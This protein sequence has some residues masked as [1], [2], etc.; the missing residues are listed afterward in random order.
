MRPSP[1]NAGAVSSATCQSCS[2]QY[3]WLTLVINALLAVLKISVGFMAGS[4]A[5]VASA[6]YSINDVLSGVTIIVSL[7][8]ARRPLDKDHAY[9]YGKAEFVAIGIVSTILVGAVVYVVMLAVAT[10][11]G[12]VNTSPHLIVLPVAALTLATTEYLARRGF[13]V[14]RRNVSPAVYTAAEHDRADSISSVAVMIGVAAAS[15]G[16]FWLDSIIAIFQAVHILWLSGVLLGAS[17]RGLMDAALPAEVVAAIRQAGSA[18]PGVIDVVTLRTR[19]VGPYAWVD[20]GVQVD[21]GIPVDEADEICA[22]V[23][24]AIRKAAA[25]PVRSQVKFHV[26]ESEIDGLVPAG[27]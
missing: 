6:L 22:R 1:S 27:S 21:R 2:L 3:S 13:C 19:H 9:G 5:L 12:G 10:L 15:V 18:V 14:A 17:I 7:R 8:A 25:R 11:V 4:R 23:D 24:E 20:I 16:I 26:Q